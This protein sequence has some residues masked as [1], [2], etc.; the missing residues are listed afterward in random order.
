VF[1]K[2]KLGDKKLTV[3]VFTQAAVTR[4]YWTLFLREFKN[5]VLEG[6]VFRRANHRQA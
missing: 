3:K 5:N 6:R 4:H 2:N 1:Q